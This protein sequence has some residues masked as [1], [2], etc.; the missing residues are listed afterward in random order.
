MDT[1]LRISVLVYMMVQAVLF[2]AVAILILATPLTSH[3]TS[4]FPWFIGVSAIV[5]LPLSWMIAPHLRAR[6]EKRAVLL[7]EA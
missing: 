5:S 4:L 3:A 6:F 7:P 1:R 2:G